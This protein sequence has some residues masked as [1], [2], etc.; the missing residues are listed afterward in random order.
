MPAPTYTAADYVQAMANLLPRGPVWRRDPNSNLMALLGGLAPTYQR[1]GAA[2]AALIPD[3]SP[4]STDS[5]LTEWEETLG[6]PDP[7]T[8]LNPTTAERKAAVLA[9]FIGSGGQSIPYF[10]AVAAA[11]GYTITVTEFSAFQ[12]GYSRL[13]SPLTNAGWESVWQVNAPQIST[14]FFKLGVSDLGD[15]FWS[16]GN[17]TLECRL[18]AIAPAHTKLIFNYS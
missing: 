2:A 6:L 17:T 16:T 8:P 4:A 10:T 5:F 7:C 13:G 15:P 14:T 12:L 1:S 18:S 11:L 3:V 9:A